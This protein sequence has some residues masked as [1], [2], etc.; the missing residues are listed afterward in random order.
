[1]YQSLPKLVHVSVSKVK[2]L[3]AE[4]TERVLDIHDFISTQ[5]GIYNLLAPEIPSKL[6]TM[7]ETFI[8]MQC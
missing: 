7:N 1:M 3:G 2:V 8:H 5:Y 6:L 4:N